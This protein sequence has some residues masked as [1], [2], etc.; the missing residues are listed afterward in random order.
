MSPLPEHESFGWSLGRL[1][2]FMSFERRI[3]IVGLGSTT[4]RDEA[5]QHGLEP[6]KCYYI[7]NAAAIRGIRGPFDPKIHPAPDLAIEID[8]TSRSIARQP[9]YASLGVPEIWR[10]TFEGIECLSLSDGQYRSVERSLSYPFLK[11]SSLWEWVQ[12]LDVE[13]D[14]IVLQE[15]K[16]WVRALA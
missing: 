15:F 7:A 8:I 16:D 4:F 6:D 10:V 5:K 2:E 3:P 13:V 9:I 1:V 14:L 11:S 12:R